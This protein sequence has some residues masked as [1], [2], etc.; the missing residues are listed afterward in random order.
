MNSW[1]S[2]HLGHLESKCKPKNHGLIWYENVPDNIVG[3]KHLRESAANTYR[4]ILTTTV[5]LQPSVS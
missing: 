4:V 3:R 1:N 2:T 5:V